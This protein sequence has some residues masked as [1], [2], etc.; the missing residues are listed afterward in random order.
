MKCQHCDETIDDKSTTCKYCGA[1]ITQDSESHEAISENETP[2]SDESISDE[3]EANDDAQTSKSESSNESDTTN[4]DEP[5]SDHKESSEE[6]QTTNNEAKSDSE[7]ANDDEPESNHQENSSEAQKSKN[8]STSDSESSDDNE[9]EATKES[10]ALL[11]IKHV[12]DYRYLSPLFVGS[13]LIAYFTI[14]YPPSMIML[15]LIVSSALIFNS[16]GRRLKIG[17]ITLIYPV[18][19]LLSIIV[20]HH[21]LGN[22]HIAKFTKKSLELN[23]K[24]PRV[25]SNGVEFVSITVP[26]RFHIRETLRFVHLSRDEAIDERE[27]IE[28]GIHKALPKKCKSLKKILNLGMKIET[29][30]IGSNKRHVFSSFITD[31]LCK[32]LY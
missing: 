7:A 32:P 28:L 15:S 27:S 3:Q 11:I 30:L 14:E 17:L 16:E 9:E 26:S 19:S 31:E 22:T 23:R 21:T 24:L 8:E 1:A 10:E 20:T 5:I 18:I 25:M 13:I 29:T 4:D 2:N 12:T 6:T